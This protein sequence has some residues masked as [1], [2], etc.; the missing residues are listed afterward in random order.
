MMDLPNIMNEV[1]PRSLFLSRTIDNISVELIIKDIININDDDDKKERVYSQWERKPIK[2][3]INTEG[4]SIYDGLALV[5]IIKMSKTPVHGICVGSA[6]S[7]GLWIYSSCHKRIIGENATLM[8]HDISTYIY[9]KTEVIKQEIKEL[10]RLQSMLIKEI[11]RKSLVKEETL[12]DYITRKAEWYISP[13][14][15]IDLRLADEYYK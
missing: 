12:R 11:M 14:E 2:L 8:F 3:Y 15:A 7:M 13:N 6:M 9:D 5:D 4:G 1:M 10:E